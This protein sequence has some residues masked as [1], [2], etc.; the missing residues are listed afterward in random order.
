M[1]EDKHEKQIV[2]L[3]SDTHLKYFVNLEKFAVRPRRSQIIK[4][5]Y[6]SMEHYNQ[7]RVRLIIKDFL[8]IDRTKKSQKKQFPG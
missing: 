7:I 5:L 6:L 8:Y 4:L 1:S 2:Y 3:V